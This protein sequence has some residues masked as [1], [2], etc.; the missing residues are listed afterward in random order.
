MRSGDEGGEDSNIM[1]LA[2]ELEAGGR[3]FP[4][5]LMAGLEVSLVQH[6]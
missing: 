6:E 5:V 4:Y 3:A 2:D 1:L